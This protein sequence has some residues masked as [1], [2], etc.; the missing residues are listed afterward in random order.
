MTKLYI[1]N[2]EEQELKELDSEHIFLKEIKKTDLKKASLS[3]K[4]RIN[5]YVL[6]YDNKINHYHIYGN[7][8]EKTERLTILW[9]SFGVILFLFIGNAIMTDNIK[10]NHYINSDVITVQQEKKLFQNIILDSLNFDLM[11]DLNTLKQK[12]EN[13]LNGDKFYSMNIIKKENYNIHSKLQL[14]PKGLGAKISIEYNSIRYIDDNVVLSISGLDSSEKGKREKSILMDT[15][16]EKNYPGYNIKI[17]MINND[18]MTVNFIKKIVIPMYQNNLGIVPKINQTIIV[19]D[20]P[21]SISQENKS[22]PN[23]IELDYTK[24]NKS[25]SK[26]ENK[27]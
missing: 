1:K 18:E 11:S 24:L 22:K 9:K 27:K 17:N 16:I 5:K 20:L 19:P 2:Y 8:Q 26:E 3:L 10:A 6:N 7:I 21:T 13:D 14:I 12:L 15:L 25:V 4:E 23:H